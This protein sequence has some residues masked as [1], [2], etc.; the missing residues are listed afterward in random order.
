MVRFTIDLGV[1]AERSSEGIAL[2][3]R[4]S[5]SD[6]DTCVYKQVPL[7]EKKPS[8]VT[9]GKQVLAL[10][11]G[12]RRCSEVTNSRVELSQGALCRDRL[13][14]FDSIDPSYAVCARFN[15]G[16]HDNQISQRHAELIRDVPVDP[17]QLS[18]SR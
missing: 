11:V 6:A 4:T 5:T 16:G 7:L 15:S 18:H 17:A 3:I 2:P 1:V 10:D 9:P 12:P 14:V 8:R 13:G